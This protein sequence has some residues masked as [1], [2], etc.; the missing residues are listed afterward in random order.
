[1]NRPFWWKARGAWYV[2]SPD[3]QQNIRLD[4][5]EKK[6]HEIWAESMAVTQPELPSAP[7]YAIAEAFLKWAEDNV[8]PKT[9]RGYAD[10]V[11][12]FAN[13]FGRIRVRELKPYHVTRWLQKN[14]TWAAAD[15]QRAAI[16]A[17]KRCLNWAVDQGLLDRNPLAGV[18]KPPG[19]RREVL[20]TD[21]QHRL[22]MEAR[23]LGRQPGKRAAA[24]GITP[25]TRDG[26]FRAVLIALKHSGTRPGMVA[27][28][29]VENI[30]HNGE[31][32]LMKDHK[33]R[34]K[35]GKPLIVYLS[36]CLQTLTRILAAGRESGPLF[37]NS[38]GKAWNSNSIARRMIGLRK[39]LKLPADAVAYS[40]RHTF[41]TA[42]LQNGVS[43]A[44]AAE[45][46]GHSDLKMIAKH[47]GH[48]DKQVEH[49]KAAAA[50]AVQKPK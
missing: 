5:D 30:A 17:V 50:K 38:K 8:K 46:A 37:R 4:P 2:K 26:Y 1:M 44:T 15:S 42:A 21:E 48:L 27:A 18:R 47:Y 20:I 19:N 35:T 13:E 16:A 49:L 6:A 22:M 33:T 10:Y 28:V 25:R 14:A 40:Y 9:L 12:S 34:K 7:V 43:L 29:Q 23:D 39:R 11:V 41:I 31:T 3:N 36:P 32:W 24:L 45:L